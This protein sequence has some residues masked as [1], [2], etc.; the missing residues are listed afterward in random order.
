VLVER[1][2]AGREFNVGIVQLPEFHVLPLAEI[3]FRASSEM[4]W[5]ILTYSGK[6][7]SGSADDRATPVRC[8]ANVEP[9]MARQIVTAATEVYYLT[10][11]RDYARVDLRV[12]SRARCLC[13]TSTPSGSRA[14]GG[15]GANARG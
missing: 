15:P 9:K 4:K 14:Q 7:S 2:I 10:G 3:E 12:T 8:P 1:Y 6:W 13:W 5:P 11:C